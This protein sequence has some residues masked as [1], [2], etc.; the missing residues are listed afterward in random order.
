M[1]KID[2]CPS[3]LVVDG[4][5]SYSIMEGEQA[6]YQTPGDNPKPPIEGDPEFENDAN[7]SSIWDD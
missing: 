3:I 2:E 4:L 1:K 6:S 7:K 5:V